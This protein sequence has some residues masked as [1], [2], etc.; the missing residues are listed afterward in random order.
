MLKNNGKTNISKYFLIS[1][2][3]ICL[4]FVTL[5]YNIENVNASD[6]NQTNDNV[7]LEI[8]TN[9]KLENSQI[10]N[11]IQ[12]ENS[13]EILSTTHKL[14]GGTFQDI[15]E[16]IDDADAGD[17]IQLS[18][19]FKPSKNLEYISVNKK[20][21]ITSNSNAIL[22]GKNN[23]QIFYLTKN[24]NG[25]VISNLKFINGYAERGGAIL[26]KGND[27]IIDNCVF[28]NNYAY[29]GGGAISSKYNASVALNTI[30]RNCHFYNNHAKIGAGA[31]SL[32]GN[33]SKVHNCIF[34]ANYGSNNEG[35]TVYGGAIQLSLDESNCIATVTDCKF[36]NNWVK[37][38]A[39]MFSHGGAGCIRDGVSYIR[40]TFINNTAGE[41]GALTYHASG[42]IQDCVFINNTATEYGGAISTGFSYNH[43]D[44]EISNCI[45]DN[46]KAPLGG[47]IQLSG[48]NIFV[49]NSNFT[50]NYASQKGGAI[51]IE[52]VNVILD[53][54][55]FKNNTVSVNGGAVFIKGETTLIQN[56]LFDSN[57]AIP[58]SSKLDDGLGGAI[59]INSTNAVITNNIFKYNTARNGSA[60][61]YDSRGINLKVTNNVM[62]EDQAW[63]YALPISTSDIYFKNKE[64]ITVVIHGGNNI[65]RY[66]NL[67]VSNAIY[68][69]AMS[70]YIDVDGFTPLQGATNS[71]ELYQD[72][73]E[74]N[75][76]ILLTV[77]HENGTLIYNNTLKTSY[78]GEINVVLNDLKPGKYYVT[79]THYED[80]YYKAI[81]NHTTFTVYPEIDNQ[82]II[83]SDKDTYNFEEIAT[84]TINITNNGPNNATGVYISELLPQGLIYLTDTSGGLYDPATGI[85]NVSTLNVDEKLSFKIQTIINKTGQIT[86]KV[87]ITAKETD[88]NLTNNFDEASIKVNPAVDI[89]VIKTTN[90]TTP[91][92]KDL[93]NWTIII[94]NNG[95]DIAHNISVKDIIPNTLIPIEITGNYNIT[96]NTWFIQSLNSKNEVKFNIITLVNATGI[97]QNNAEAYP[98]EFDY[99]L[100]NNKDD[101]I[102]KVQSSCDLAII[103]LVNATPVNYQDLV[104]WTLIIKNNG[105]DNA[106]GVKITDI[107]PEGFIYVNSTLPY[108]NEVIEIGNLKVGEEKTLDIICIADNTG[109]FTNTANITGNEYD[110]N[111]SN[112][113]DDENITVKPATDIEVIKEVDENQPEFGQIV[114]WTI[115]IKNNGPDM[116]HNITV[117]D[118]LPEGLIWI[119]DDSEGDYNP[120]TGIWHIDSLDVDDEITLEILTK[121][122]KTGITQNNVSTTANE[123]D[124]NL[125][126]N[127]DNETI[128]VDPSADV[129]IIKLVNNT[130]PNYKDII[131]WT[132]IV[133]NNGPDKATGVGV[134]EKIPEGLIIISSNATKGYYE[135]DLWWVCCLE[136][137]EIETLEIICQVNKTGLIMNK[138]SIF[139][140][141][142]D[143]NPNNNEA[144]ESITVPPAVDI[145]VIHEVTNPTPLFNDNVTWL[146]IIKNNGPDNASEVK[147]T[148]ILPESLTFITYNSTKGEYN[149]GIWNVGSLNVDE[150]EYL[151]IT[152]NTRQLGETI[153]TANAISAEYDWNKTNNLDN[154]KINVYPVADL[155]IEKQVNKEKPNYND[156]VTW[157]LKIW[158][159]GP[160]DALNVV[161]SDVLPAQLKFIKASDKN[162]HGG[163]WH[164]GLLK[165][166]EVKQLTIKTKVIAT[167]LIINTADIWSDNHDPNPE[168]NHANK[169][170]F[171]KPA[172]DLSIT[173]IASK[174]N[175]VVGD[176]IEYIIEVV[177]NGPDTAYNVKINEILD[178]LLKLKSFK[179]TDGR[180]MKNSN[181]WF[182]KKLG[183]GESARLYLK[184]IA[185]GAGMIENKVFVTSDSFDYDDSNNYARAIVKVVNKDLNNPEHDLDNNVLDNHKTAN[186]LM[187]LIISAIFLLFCLGGNISKKR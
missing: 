29:N 128:E 72:N 137:D 45:F 81:T 15:Q 141:E 151:N 173:K 93:V 78:L 162:Y 65:G 169:S 123:Y 14:N 50:N 132:I 147:L 13:N 112:N 142:Y 73:R 139:E 124:Y 185:I 11:T 181:V 97:I 118:K 88:S 35:L 61:Y 179:V 66:G 103:K 107:L 120:Q 64:N 85:L 70:Q 101:E 96:N 125:T 44:L 149:N 37:S 187:I 74:Y 27:A 184:V 20:L 36:M 56:S 175:Y 40:C 176:V 121:V 46:N 150:I 55:V 82:I 102:I 1:I 146:I 178:D 114:T 186:P 94:R 98:S 3:I 58:D 126:N 43:M 60:I 119:E 51:N 53:N 158:N 16:C 92:Y 95:P 42:K 138:V 77:E 34:D 167:G 24:G 170:V 69:A 91:N 108:D 136:K 148:D 134:N 52:A 155:A 127:D 115:T 116:A 104:K 135:D 19:T 140:N 157:T 177:N 168:N 143:P 17:T 113:Q 71:G 131:K 6:I 180:F 183:N 8:D 12:N 33:N 10:E 59:Y 54:G 31:L 100:S 109:N 79:A 76:D 161:V 83:T 172:S 28:E 174:Y 122:N 22:D 62:H 130:T 105:P 39:G 23:Y 48:E 32:Y 18:G 153:N 89:M 156:I 159:N 4:M 166:G 67:D 129:S 163:D 49:Y 99:D 47:A 87:N 25:V 21:T 26:I 63:V 182:I 80:T 117:Y 9:D 111:P 84:W 171:V 30:V 133:T 5:G 164:V 165:V 7:Q 110:Y 75:I 90:N 86:N 144:N 160:N 154:A 2:F 38:N 57:Q 145:E 152:S 106:T 41:G 68:N